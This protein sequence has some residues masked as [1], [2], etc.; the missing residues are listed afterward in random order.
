MTTTLTKE[1]NTSIFRVEE[2]SSDCRLCHGSDSYCPITPEAQVQSQVSPRQIYGG[3][4][5][6]GAGFSLSTVLV[7]SPVSIIP[8]ILI[9]SFIHPSIYH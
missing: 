4:S 7:F 6:T 1:P 5:G 2:T 9:H 8:P 3:Q